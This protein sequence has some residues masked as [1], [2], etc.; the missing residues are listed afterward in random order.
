MSGNTIYRTLCSSCR[1]ASTCTFPR[2]PQKPALY[3]EEFEID[4]PPSKKTPGIAKS[5]PVKPSDAKAEGSPKLIGLCSDCENSKTC[6]FPKPEG[7]VWHCEEY[8]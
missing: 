2:D 4:T 6:A 5:R 3:C 1:H 7:G 8:K